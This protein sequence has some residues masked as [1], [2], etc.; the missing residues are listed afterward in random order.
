MLATTQ[1]Y[2][3]IWAETQRTVHKLF[4]VKDDRIEIMGGE[5]VL[6]HGDFELGSL[7]KGKDILD[8]TGIELGACIRKLED[9]ED[10]KKIVEI[11]DISDDQ[12]NVI[13]ERIKYLTRLKK[14][15]KKAVQFLNIDDI[16]KEDAV[17]S[18]NDLVKVASGDEI[19]PPIEVTIII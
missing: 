10:I 1:N 16:L 18:I 6:T 3:H 2:Y 19:A 5:G 17:I 8:R 7:R 9:V 14:A 15:M 12:V 11:E 13:K 4:K